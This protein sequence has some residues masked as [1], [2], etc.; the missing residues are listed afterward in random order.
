MSFVFSSSLSWPPREST[1]HRRSPPPRLRRLLA[2]RLEQRIALD[3][4]PSAAVSGPTSPLIGEEID[5]V[6]TFDNT[7]T[8]PTDIGYSPFVDIIMPAHGDAPPTPYNGISFKGTTATYNG[9][10]L[11]AQVLTFPASGTLTHPFAIDPSTGQPLEI[12]GQ[13]E[14][15]QFVVIEL[16][17]GSYAP[18]QPAID[19]HFTGVVS[20]DAQTMSSY[21]VKAT[22]GFRYQVD[23]AGNPTVNKAIMGTETTDPVQPQVFRV[24]KNSNAPESETV[25]GPNFTHTYT[26]NVAVAPGQTVTDFLV[27]DTLP[28]ALQFVSVGTVAGHGSTTVTNVADPSTTTPGGQLARKFDQVVGTGSDS[29]VEMSFTYYVAQKNAGGT[30]VIPLGTGGT[31]TLTNKSQAS[32]TWTSTNQNF[33]SPQTVQSSATDPDALHVLTATTLG[34]RKS[35]T[36]LTQ[37]GRYAVGDTIEYTLRF[38]VSDFFAVGSAVLSDTLSDGQQFDASFT[39]TLQYE[40]QS[41]SFPAASMSGSNYSTAVQ[42]DGTEL[43]IFSLADELSLRGLTSGTNLLGAGVPLGGTGDP[44]VPPA[45]QPIVPGTTG[46]VKFRAVVTNSYRNPPSSGSAVVQGDRMTDTARLT[47]SVLKYED[48][49]N[50]SN[51]VTN[52]SQRSFTLTSGR[53]T[54]SVFAINGNPPAAN[55]RVAPGDAVTFQITYDVPFSSIDNYTLTDFLPLPI[56]VASPLTFAGGV[57]S[58]TPPPA[59]Q[60]SFGPADTFSQTDPPVT[61]GIG[62]PSPTNASFPLTVSTDTSSNSITWDF[63]SYDDPS[64]RDGKTDI[65]FTVTATNRPFGDGLLLT[66]QAQQHETDSSGNQVKSAPGITQI[67]VGEPDLQITKGVVSTNNATGEFVQNGSSSATPP[68]PSGVNFAPP[69]QAGSGFTGTIISGPPD[70]LATTPIDATL[71]NVLG[72]DLVKFSIIVENTGSSPNGAFDVMVKDTLD[73]RYQVPPS[74][75]NLQ[76]TDGAGTSLAY[77]G[78]LFNAGITLVDQ[79]TS[80]ASDS[81]VPYNA[82]TYTPG[83]PPPNLGTGFGPWTIYA[84]TSSGSFVGATALGAKTF[85]V[86]SNGTGENGSLRAFASPLAVGQAFTADIA[87]TDFTDGRKG[88][89]FHGANEPDRYAVF[90]YVEQGT[91]LWKYQPGSGSP[92]VDSTIPFVADAAIQ[93]RLEQ[94]S[95]TTALLSMTQAGLATWSATVTVPAAVDQAGF[96]SSGSASP[97]KSES[98][99]FDNLA[100]TSAPALGAL[101]PGT[102]FDGTVINTGTNIA[103][104]TYDLQIKPTAAPLEVIPNTATL[105]NYASIEGGPNFLSP[106]GL[107]DDTDVTIKGAEISKTLVGTSIVDAYN[108]DTQAV[109]GELATFDIRVEVPRGITPAA[110]ITDKLTDA[111]GFVRASVVYDN[112][113]TIGNPSGATSPTLSHGSSNTSLATFDLGDIVNTNPDDQLHGLTIT[114]ETVVLNDRIVPQVVANPVNRAELTWTGHGPVQAAATAAHVIEP[115]VTVNKTVNTATAQASDT[116]TFSITVSAASTTSHDVELSDIFP[117]GITYVP[118][119]LRATGV[120]P[121]KLDVAVGGGGFEVAWGTLVPGQTST[122]TFEATLDATVTSGQ[123]ITNPANITWTSLGDNKQ[124]TTNY[125]NAYQ[126]SGSGLHTDR[127]LN[128]YATSDSATITVA[129]PTVAKSLV[130]TSIENTANSRTQAVIGELATY[131]ITVTIPQGRTPAAQLID[132]MN[133]GLAF[134]QQ[135]SAVN[136][137]PAV[138]TVP[139]LSNAPVL[140]GNGT[141]ATWNLGDIVNSDTDSSTAETITF[142]IDTVVL[143][144]NSNTSGKRLSN[145]GQLKWN[146]RAT[147]S[148]NAQNRDVTVIE[149]KLVTTKTASVGGFGGNPGDPVTYTIVIEHDPGSQTDAYDVTLDDL[150]PAEIAS[151]RLTSVAGISAAYFNLTGNT[152]STTSPFYFGKNPAGHTIT[153]TIEGTLQGP[154]TANQQFVNTDYVRWTSLSGDPSQITPNNPNAY[155]R[156]GSGATNQG[157]LN[158]YV[159]SGTATID[160]NTADLA[161][162]KSVSNP[163]PNVAETVTFTVT[164]T[165]N[166]PDTATA[167]ELTDTFPAAGLQIVGTPAA[168]QG[169]YAAATG[170]WDVGTLLTGGGNAQTLTI[171]AL[172]LAPAVNTIPVAQTNVATVTNSVE[173]DPDPGNN[174]GTAT[175]TPKYADLGIKKTT[176]NPTP[177]VGDTVTYTV[178]LFNLGTAEATGVK[179]TDTFPANVTYLTHS[180]AVG[181]FDSVT[182]IW[183]VGTVPLSATVSSPLTLTIQVLADSATTGFNVVTITHSDVWDP[184]N[185]NNIAKT[186]TTGLEAD[187]IL[188]KTADETRPNVGDTITYTVTVDNAGPS[189]AQAVIVVDQIPT[190]TTYVPGSA[191]DGGTYNPAT[192][193][194]TW[195]LGNNFPLGQRPLTVQAT[196]DTP[197]SGPIAPLANTATV[198]S[199]TTDPNPLNNTDTETL[200]PLQ[201]DLAVFKVVSDS[202]PNV[203]ETIQFAL[204]AA[205]FGPNDATN[206]V[207]TDVIPVGVT[208]VGLTS[209]IGTNPT[210]GSFSYDAATRTLTW[211]IGGLNTADFPILVFDAT[212]NA[213]TPASVPPTVTNT[214]T[215]TGTEYDPDLSNNTDSV[216]ETPQ[217]ADLEVTK[218]VNDPTPNV[219]DTITYT[220]TVT[221]NGADTAT[222]VTLLDTLRTLPGLQITGTPQANFGSFDQ[223]TGIWTIGTVNVGVAATLSIQA[224]VLAPAS[225]NPLPQTN[226]ASI[227]TAD[228]YDPVPG[229]NAATATET[230][231]YADLKVTKTVSNPAPNVGSDVTFTID[232]ENLG[233]NQATNVLIDD[234]LPAGLTFLSAS[235]Q[236]YDPGTGIW[237]V[238]TIDAGTANKKTLTITATVAVS[239]SFTNEAEVSTTS[240]PDQYDPD[241]LNNKGSATV[242]TREADLVVAKTVDRPSPNVGDLITFT[243]TV[244]NDGPDGANNV[245]VTDTFPTSGLQ[246]VGAPIASQGSFDVGT[247]VWTIGGIGVGAG[248]QQTLTIEARVLP[249]PVDTIPPSQTNRA[250]VT[251]VDEHDPNPNNNQSQVTEQPRYTDL[252]VTKTTSNVQPNVGDTFTYTVTL[253]NKGKE[254]ATNVEVIEA[255]PNNID[256]LRVTPTNTHTTT[257][258]VEN[259]PG[260][261]GTWTIPSIAPGRSEVLVIIARA[262]SANIAYNTVTITHSDVWDPNS[263]NNQAR[264]PTD[265]QQADLVLSKTVDVSRPEVN[266]DVVFTL[267]LENLGPTAAANVTVSDLLPAGLGFVSANPAGEYNAGV[268]TVGTVDP[269]SANARTLTITATVLPPASGSGHVSDSVNSATATST[270]VDPNPG[271]NTDTAT[272]TPLEADLS[273]YKTA[274]SLTP[275]IGTTFQYTVQVANLGADTASNVQVTDQLPAGVTFDSYTATAGTYDAVSGIWDIGTVTTAD[276][277]ELVIT[278]LVTTGNSGGNVLNTATVTSGTWDPDLSNNT[279]QQ[280]VVVPPRGVIVGTDVG[281]ETGPFVRVIDP[282]TGAN[283]ITPFFA[284]EPSFRGGVRVYGAD[285]TG[286]GIPEIITAPGPGRPGEVRVFSETG[287]LLPAYSF[288][289]FGPGYAGGIEIA[290]GSVTAA[291]AIE[292]VTAQNR[293]GTVNVFTV[294]P[295]AATPVASSPVRQI[296]PFGA[297]Y[298]SGFFIDTA[299]VGTFSGTT[300]TSASPDGIKELFVGTGAGV[301]AA[302][303]GYDAQPTTPVAFN[304]FQPL[305]GSKAGASIARLPS[306]TLGAADKLLV[307]AGARGGSL[308][309][310]YSGTGSTREA[311]FQAYGSNLAQVFSA[312]IDDTAI[313]NVQG[314]LGTDNGVQKN[315]STSGTGSSILPQSTVSYPPLRVGILRS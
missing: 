83:N 75:L 141:V 183:D 169:T 299:D 273:I 149:P 268:W 213:P 27:E 259:T 98:I 26:V 223:T 221:N 16:P 260:T 181:T 309:E 298:Q 87:V 303:L 171:Q 10:T 196:V 127:Q 50:T 204:G 276:R 189:L 307:S 46:V 244:R 234:V 24:T 256:V 111:F 58:P 306:S 202:A 296:Q 271:N 184:N 131:E 80:F 287:A 197:A 18:A 148:N 217:H 52:G 32:G 246:I 56:F 170:V 2:E 231:Q 7:S 274:S 93:I 38:Q 228:Q 1:T 3:A 291:G 96:F 180:T 173:P 15:D 110:V 237:T 302:V 126:R 176:S 62:G 8:T 243:V 72:N 88:F 191:S 67:Q 182:G 23:A 107:P 275:Q 9:L 210:Q 51:L 104:I 118:N 81:A 156:T 165:N 103:V 5:F 195:S 42:S 95:N 59:G 224:E 76:V 179:V 143:N 199:T 125:P 108:S 164:V 6:V 225:G 37:S 245:E 208:Y 192:R 226:T 272:V 41:Q 236:A 82:Q 139:G 167:V 311:F 314:L 45:P 34:L 13:K 144:V 79:G 229:N 64:N 290:A 137:D 267:T 280:A 209:G 4:T 11:P 212:A 177:N 242:I 97:G 312:A 285:V 249:P 19:L 60:W 44:N 172:V 277:P 54:K 265:P 20:S 90:V 30:D 248:S 201:T 270:T 174:T 186:P 112:G 100:L 233:A 135:I 185:R 43:V 250:A 219:G 200:T 297:A 78:D 247:G 124:I 258:W 222:G 263:G 252:A 218:Q 315:Q 289:P 255:F 155:E 284:Y 89:G 133:P 178:S 257:R 188:S 235:S 22:G 288:F 151:P 198:T 70:G 65:L 47:A 106:A 150:I 114:V 36:N 193:E 264:T 73:A 57:A 163:T 121:Q 251:K 130:G 175:V 53:A 152:L 281:C 205:N 25:T 12:T 153:L 14:G 105:T 66:N 74:G 123:A 40:Q 283:R 292:I 68:L 21:S 39:P 304:S 159:A 85:G 120:Q 136:N 230:P 71:E 102:Q 215:I 158:N 63:G 138:L 216:S 48:L 310:T 55:Q 261:G 308:V 286:D 206:V 313:F 128:N 162:T 145:R 86:T 254:T 29:D 266:S 146:N 220:I 203:G 49:A 214:A 282:D 101:G 293:G 190:G 17:F 305:G 147:S 160:V 61:G 154:F 295:G 142:R 278:V 116:V 33:P 240:P 77:V 31:T 35:F 132:R 187:L 113:V 91:G 161:V 140:T 109:I 207:V 115:K 301:T 238:G 262:T 294:T 253:T 166:G 129:K 279:A 211:T 168:S 134:V 194:V 300:Q 119:S 69:G 269:G 122:I 84:P 99:G 227:A 117:G 157:Q 239:G 241:A 232:V 92:A 94:T 28:D